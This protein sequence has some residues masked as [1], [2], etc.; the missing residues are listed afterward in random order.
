[1]PTFEV[2][3]EIDI[4]AQP[5]EVW[6]ILSDTA[7]WSEWNPYLTRLTGDIAVGSTI[8]A[9]VRMADGVEAEFDSDI[10]VVHVNKRLSWRGGDDAG[11]MRANHIF[12][13][14]PRDSG[15]L[16][17]HREAFAGP[18]AE[19]AYLDNRQALSDSFV[20]MN[21]ALKARAEA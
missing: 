8:H 2:R 19:K 10:D 5:A 21:E 6:A 15:C 14:E 12:E 7:R 16:F 18:K 3:T 1:M 17:V 11:D 9:N 20:L 4:D 13:I